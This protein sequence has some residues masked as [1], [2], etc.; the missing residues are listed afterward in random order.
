MSS[1]LDTLSNN[2]ARLKDTLQQPLTKDDKKGRIALV[3][4]LLLMVV[5]CVVLCL[6]SKKQKKKIGKKNCK[7]CGTGKQDS[8]PFGPQQFFIESPKQALSQNPP[9][10][11]IDRLIVDK[12]IK[13]ELSVSDSV[14][15]DGEGLSEEQKQLIQIPSKLQ[16]EELLDFTQNYREKLQNNYEIPNLS[17]YRIPEHL[18]TEIIGT[19]K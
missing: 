5:I 15:F 3:L 14:L 11:S 4:F 19:T 10:S 8:K 6:I 7:S 9:V 16:D 13:N 2:Q 17:H 1:L 18:K 12:Q